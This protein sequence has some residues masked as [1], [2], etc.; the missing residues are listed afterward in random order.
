MKKLERSQLKNVIGGL[1]APPE[2]GGP[3]LYSGGSCTG[4]VGTWE[5]SPPTTGNGCYADIQRYCS[6]GRGTCTYNPAPVQS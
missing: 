1:T 5:M 3:Y 6:S 4:S 2:G